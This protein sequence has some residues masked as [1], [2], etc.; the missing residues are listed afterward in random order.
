MARGIPVTKMK[1]YL[2]VDLEKSFLL[3]G[4]TP[5]QLNAMARHCR[6]D[7]IDVKIARKPL[8]YPEQIVF[9]ADGLFERV[10]FPDNKVVDNPELAIVLDEL[11]P[12]DIW[13][14]HFLFSDDTENAS[15]IGLRCTGKGRLV[16]MPVMRFESYVQRLPDLQRAFF[17]M[18]LVRNYRQSLRLGDSLAKLQHS[19]VVLDRIE[20]VAELLMDSM[21]GKGEQKEVIQRKFLLPSNPKTGADT[22]S[23]KK[24]IEQA[25]LSSVAGREDRIR[26]E[27]TDTYYRTTKFGQGTQRK[28][29]KR[30]ILKPEYDKLLEKR[31]GEVILKERESLQ[32]KY[33]KGKVVIDRFKEHLSGLVFVEADFESLDDAEKF[34][35]PGFLQQNGVKDITED[36]AYSNRSLALYGRPE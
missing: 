2:I 35:L 15:K 33:M 5:E 16:I 8:D 36:K 4:I 20:S 9:I 26:R 30:P 12:G 32:D 28:V 10:F 24:E 17:E 13:G 18:L 22:Q 11:K 23:V 34:E 3:S 19:D 14:E 27:G 21:A 31:D 29:F 1:S 25:Y 6:V 7:E